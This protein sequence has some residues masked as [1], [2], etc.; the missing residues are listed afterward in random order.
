MDVSV[1]ENADL[2]LFELTSYR[3]LLLSTLAKH[4]ACISSPHHLLNVSKTQIANKHGVTKICP[5][6][7]QHQ[8]PSNQH[9]RYV[10]FTAFT[11]KN[12]L[13]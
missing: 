8:P 5:C 6:M 9:V 1:L 11:Q 3:G 4:V 13:I 10:C 2:P 7:A 12:I